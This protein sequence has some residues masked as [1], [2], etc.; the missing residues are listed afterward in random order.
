MGENPTEK[1]AGFEHASYI[2]YAMKPHTLF[3][4][5]LLASVRAMRYNNHGYLLY[6]RFSHS[7]SDCVVYFL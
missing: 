5:V 7:F 1:P 6:F 2:G 3:V 4:A